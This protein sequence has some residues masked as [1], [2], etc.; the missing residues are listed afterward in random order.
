MVINLDEQ[1]VYYDENEIYSFTSTP[2]L[3]S[4]LE[5]FCENPNI[6]L[7]SNKICSRL[8]NQD[9]E[10]QDPR[11]KNT[12][13][14]LRRIISKEQY[15]EFAKSIETKANGYMYTGSKIVDSAK[16]CKSV[17]DKTTGHCTVFTKYQKR[18][19]DKYEKIRM[20]FS[21][22]DEERKLDDIY[23]CNILGSR[24]E[25][26]SKKRA[27][28]KARGVADVLIENATLSELRDYSKCV[29]LIAIGGMGKSMMLQH[30]FLDSIKQYAITGLMPILVKLKDFSGSK[31][32]FCDYIVKSVTKLDSS[33]NEESANELLS[34]GKCQI[35]LDAADEIDQSDVK[36]FHTQLFE[37]MDKYPDNQYVIAS[38]ECEMVRGL[39]NRFSRLYLRAFTD[40]QPEL[41]IKKL[42]PEKK[43]STLRQEINDYLK[44]DFMQRH[45]I[46][47]TN[48]MMLTFI[49]MMFPIRETF[50]GKKYLFYHTAYETM[51]KI[52]DR[53]KEAYDRIYH[54][55]HDSDEFTM[56]FREFCAITYINQVHEFDYLSFE[57]YFKELTSV[58]KLDNKK[59]MTKENFIH[60]ACATAC[61]M[62][63]ADYKYLYIDPGFQEFLFAEY[64][65]LEAPEKIMEMSKKLWIAPPENYDGYS[66]FDMFCEF[67]EDKVEATYFL[68]YL[69]D[70]FKGKTDD[71]AFISFLRH[72]YRE[73]EY[74]VLDSDLVAQYMSKRNA[75]WVGLNPLIGEPSNVMF[76]LI[77]RTTKSDGLLA[78][79]VFKDKL[80]YPE[81]MT[82]GIFG[83]EY[84]DPSEK[85][86]KVVARRLI[87]QY[88]ENTSDY[89][90]THN[91]EGF[92]RDSE[93]KLMCFGHEYKIDFEKVEENPQKYQELIDILKTEDEG[94]WKAFISVKNYYSEINKKHRHS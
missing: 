39:K 4:M 42:L 11:P 83:E 44:S 23:V 43:D 8:Y 6:V 18:A 19:I 7:D 10:Y 26:V 17:L 31:D 22:I 65:Y 51:V 62:Y 58:E 1:K 48:P 90:K 55:A 77:L 5:Y 53:E 68:P 14:R 66:A 37:F 38:R 72:G 45:S 86:N 52:H 71:N 15:P 91:V 57:K 59:I 73:L 84:Y 2:L 56:V 41:L 76:S 54:S 32:L 79:A 78:F 16:E 92:I 29:A 80:N 81:F 74:Q 27:S 21:D 63:E 30:L 47:R 87:R 46:F 69:N 50:H 40:K 82:A 89:E 93:K 13:S 12:I 35:L 85:K 9:A 3:F 28:L 64:N 88:A 33:F 20:P 94:L 60:D 67:S 34:L 25:P 75:N 61:M 70:I 36:D 24:I 49:I